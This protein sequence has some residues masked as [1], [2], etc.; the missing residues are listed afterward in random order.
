MQYLRADYQTM[1]RRVAEERTKAGDF[2][3]AKFAKELVGTTSVLAK[4][5]KHTPQPI[6]KGSALANLFDGVELTRKSLLKTLAHHGV[7]P[8]DELVGTQFDP[9]SHEAIFQVPPQVAPKRPDGSDRAGGEI[10][11]VQTQ[12]WLIKERVLVPAQVGVVQI[13]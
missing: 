2:A 12:G 11:E 9:N 6:E 1:S 13:E 7:T 5:L 3:I 10:I 4:A 8:M